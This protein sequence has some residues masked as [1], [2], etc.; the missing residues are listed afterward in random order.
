MSMDD[1]DVEKDGG[2]W[3]APGR[4]SVEE[5]WRKMQIL[6]SLRQKG[7]TRYYGTTRAFAPLTG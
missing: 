2:R 7:R 6:H 3:E 5:F 1:S 4:G